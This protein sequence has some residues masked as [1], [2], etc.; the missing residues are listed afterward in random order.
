MRIGP[1]RADRVLQ[2]IRLVRIVDEH[3]R[4]SPAAAHELKPALGTFQRLER[5]HHQRFVAP[6]ANDETRRDERIRRLEITDQRQLHPVAV[7]PH[8]VSSLLAE[9]FALNLDDAKRLAFPPNGEQVEP[10]RLATCR[11]LCAM[12][13]IDIDDRRRT[14]LQQ[15]FEQPHLGIEIVLDRRVIVEMVVREIGEST[16]GNPQPVEPVLVEAMA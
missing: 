14:R 5:M 9:A 1:E 10:A 8:L 6:G 11:S 3:R 2:R 15:V 16:G 4:A 13:A 12:V 7:P